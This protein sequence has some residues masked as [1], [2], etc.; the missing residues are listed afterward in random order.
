MGLS[1]TK[2]AQMGILRGRVRARAFFFLV[3]VFF[4]HTRW[5]AGS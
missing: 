3:V 2:D 4:G 1:L 5:L